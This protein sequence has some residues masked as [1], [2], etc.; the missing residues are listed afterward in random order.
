MVYT[1][2]HVLSYSGMRKGEIL[3]LMW[4]DINFERNEIRINKQFHAV[5][6]ANCT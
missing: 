6:N 2:F 5:R 1:I 3:A 4:N